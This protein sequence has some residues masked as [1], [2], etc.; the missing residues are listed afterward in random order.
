M[1][2]YI[3]DGSGFLF[4]AYYGYPA[5]DNADGMNVNMIYGFFRIL[6]KLMMEKPDYLLVTWDLPVATKR[7]EIDSEYK[8]NRPETPQDFKQ[9]IPIVHR[10]VDELGIPNRWVNWYEAD[11][12]IAT[13]AKAYDSPDLQINIISSD[14]D[15]K[16]LLSENIIIKDLMKDEIS[17]VQSFEKQYG[18]PPKLMLD[19]LA[20]IWDS[21]DNIK[22]VPGIWPKSADTLIKKYQTIEKIYEKIDEIWWSLQKKLIDGK[23]SAFHSK[24]L[25]ELMDVPDLHSSTL[26]DFKLDVDIWRY[27]KVL[28]DDNKFT[29]MAKALDDFKKKIYAPTQNSL[30]G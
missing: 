1:K 7:H 18:F 26:A 21:A 24:I 14:K 23:T 28:I 16:Q 11:D 17:T 12:V 2:F 9:Q 10:L 30:F 13:I 19:Y 5:M 29:S 27:K 6:L 4:R 8:A 25:I 15:L 20:L 3:I 22:W